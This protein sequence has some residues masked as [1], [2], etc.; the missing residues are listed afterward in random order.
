MEISFRTKKLQKQYENSSEAVKAYGSQIARKFIMRVNTLKAAKN[1][2]ELYS[3][4]GWDFHPLTGDR[5]GEYAIKLTG[6]WR[7]I[8]TNDGDSFDIAKIEEVSKHYGD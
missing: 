1:F 4:P 5:K 3:L 2:D 7:L 8:I 6:F